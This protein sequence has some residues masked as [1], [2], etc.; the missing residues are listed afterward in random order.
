MRYL[1]KEIEYDCESIAN[2]NHCCC[3][4]P[5]VD[6]QALLVALQ[7]RR[8]TAALDVTDPEPLPAEHPLWKV[9]IID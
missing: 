8:I 1:P 2:T 4:G 3:R 5:Q 7:S 6:T 9:C